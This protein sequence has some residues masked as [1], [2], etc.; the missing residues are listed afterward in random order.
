VRD[1]AAKGSR[2]CGL[3]IDVDPLSV[4]GCVREC[5]YPAPV[6]EE[7]VRAPSSW[8][9]ACPNSPIPLKILKAHS[10]SL[11]PLFNLT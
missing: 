1:G 11:E 9:A 2:G 3:G 6:D 5:V 7:P 4:V 10:D 8:P